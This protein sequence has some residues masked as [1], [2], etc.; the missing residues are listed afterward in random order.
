[1]SNSYL[2]NVARSAICMLAGAAWVAGSPAFAGSRAVREAAAEMAPS[3]V[4]LAVWPPAATV[5]DLQARAAQDVPWPTSSWTTSTPEAQGLDSAVLADALETIRARNLP[6]HS[7]LIARHGRIVLDAYFHPFADNQL[8]DLAS[9]TKSVISTLVGIAWGERRIGSLNT[10]VLALLPD[11]GAQ[12]D[13]LKS[14]IT[15][16]IF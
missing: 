1:M 15:L 10:P 7:L 14:R 16:D 12:G 11:A 5:A 6:V 3:A 4:A 8:H 13:P 2:G 9:V